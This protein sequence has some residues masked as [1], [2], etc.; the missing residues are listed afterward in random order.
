MLVYQRVNLPHEYVL[1][2][3]YSDHMT[4]AIRGSNSFSASTFHSCA[5]WLNLATLPAE[6]NLYGPLGLMMKNLS[7]IIASGYQPWTNSV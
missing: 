4:I 2:F 6:L 3:A 5:S 7:K 1:L